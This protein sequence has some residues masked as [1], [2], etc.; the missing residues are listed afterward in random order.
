M[1]SCGRPLIDPRVSATGNQE[2]LCPLTDLGIAERLCRVTPSSHGERLCWVVHGS[3]QG[4]WRRLIS[5]VRDVCEDIREAVVVDIVHVLEYLRKAT[6]CF[7]PAG[8]HVAAET[9]FAA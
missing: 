5:R 2:S 8:D 1:W 6:W 4:S 9:R 3:A 7:H